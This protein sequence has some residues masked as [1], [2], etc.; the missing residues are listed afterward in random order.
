MVFD[1]SFWLMVSFVLLV[2]V[3]GHKIYT[4]LRQQLIDRS[5]DI[6]RQIREISDLHDEAQTLYFR[7][8][9]RLKKTRVM[10]QE[11]VP[12]ATELAATIM[13]DVKQKVDRLNEQ[14]EKDLKRRYGLIENKLMSDIQEAVA[15]KICSLTE[16]FVLEKLTQDARNSFVQSQIPHIKLPH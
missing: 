10:A 16:T 12:R 1:A 15:E 7:E 3:C 13:E 11:A 8:R 9:T 14:Q 6:A 4:V 5:D 2:G